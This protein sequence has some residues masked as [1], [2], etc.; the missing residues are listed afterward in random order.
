[1]GK[2]A[3]EKKL[4]KLATVVA[5]K[6]LIEKR[7]VERVLPRVR[8][9]KK[10]SLALVATVFLLWVGSVVLDKINIWVNKG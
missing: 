10:I 1:M 3:Q 7:K 9:A 4:A 8:Y 5:E 6:Q 2:R